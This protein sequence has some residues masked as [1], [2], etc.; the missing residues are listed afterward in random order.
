[1]PY[2]LGISMPKKTIKSQFKIKTLKTNI[3]TTTK[4]H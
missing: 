1:M 3:I 4:T 2:P